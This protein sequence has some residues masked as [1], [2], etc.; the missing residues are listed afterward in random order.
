MSDKQ[1][2]QPNSQAEYVRRLRVL[3]DKLLERA[4]QPEEAW[5]GRP[6]AASSYTGE[7]PFL[8]LVEQAERMAREADTSTG[9]T[10]N[11]V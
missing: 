6:R 2:Q 10:S 8:D 1:P 9:E 3:R 11:G 4:S 5:S 7:R